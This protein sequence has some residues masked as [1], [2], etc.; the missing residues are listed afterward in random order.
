MF[1]GL[2]R[3]HSLA[4]P[5]LVPCLPEPAKT[6]ASYLSLPDW[7]EREGKQ[8][9]VSSKKGIKKIKKSNLRFVT[10]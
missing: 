3:E 8:E 1:V 7:E 10:A 2:L 6:T 4:L 9:N 5:S